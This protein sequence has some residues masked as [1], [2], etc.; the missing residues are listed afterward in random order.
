M[1]LVL[2]RHAESEGNAEGRFQGHRD[3]PLTSRGLAQARRLAE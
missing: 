3:Y 1:R 2:I